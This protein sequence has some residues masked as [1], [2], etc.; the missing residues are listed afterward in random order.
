MFLFTF[1]SETYNDFLAFCTSNG[2]TKEFAIC[3]IAVA[4]LGDELLPGGGLVIP[5]VVPLEDF[6]ELIPVTLVS[7]RQN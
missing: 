7:S 2:S 1:S 6:K 4:K 5:G 3:V